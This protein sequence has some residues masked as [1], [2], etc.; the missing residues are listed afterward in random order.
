MTNNAIDLL[1]T[2]TPSWLS[3]GANQWR[4]TF[5]SPLAASTLGV[6]VAQ[7]DAAQIPRGASC[8]YYFD[9]THTLVMAFACGIVR[10]WQ[11]RQMKRS[12]IINQTLDPSSSSPSSVASP[13]SA[14]HEHQGYE[15][16]RGDTFHH[17]DGGDVFCF[18]RVGTYLF[19]GSI[20][21]GMKHP[22]QPLC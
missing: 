17:D 14:S 18:T 9:D 19:S 10:T 4:G 7:L 8:S 1:L 21:D 3:H 22:H 13:A 16:Y 2:E 5:G 15:W 6:S 20:R 11:Y 12:S